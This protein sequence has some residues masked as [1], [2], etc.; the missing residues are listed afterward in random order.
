MPKLKVHVGDKFGD[1]VVEKIY[2]ANGM[3][4]VCRCKCGNTIDLY[5]SA[6]LKRKNPTCGCERLQPTPRKIPDRFLDMKGKVFG[7]LEVIDVY[8]L[9]YLNK[10]GMNP[11]MLRCKC[12]KCGSVTEPR[13]SAVLSGQIM[14]CNKCNLKN[15]DKGREISKEASVE[16]TKITLI[17]GRRH[18]NKNNTTGFNGV[19]HRGNRYR[20]YIYFKRKQ[21]SLGIYDTPEEAAAARKEA[22]ERIYGGF[23]QWYAET[24]P[25]QWERITHGTMNK[26]KER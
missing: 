19:S 18:R 11:V 26:K 7:D 12:V 20:A 13:A 21:Y 4:C 5:T 2:L 10:Q 25:E 24:Y 22:E 3:R 16:G 15:L 8:K 23:L 17:D 14:G 6:L 9:G 1:L